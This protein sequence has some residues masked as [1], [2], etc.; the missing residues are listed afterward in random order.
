MGQRVSVEQRLQ[1]IKGYI[2]AW[3]DT[4]L[5]F[6]LIN[7]QFSVKSHSAERKSILQVAPNQ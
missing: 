1:K 7:C 3:T 5:F 4:I 6:L 2:R